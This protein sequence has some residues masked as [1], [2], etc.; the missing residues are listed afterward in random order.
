MQRNVLKTLKSL[1]KQTWQQLPFKSAKYGICRFFLIPSTPDTRV[2]MTNPKYSLCLSQRRF[3]FTRSLTYLLNVGRYASF[4]LVHYCCMTRLIGK[5]I[6]QKHH[7][8]KQLAIV[9]LHNNDLRSKVR[10]SN[11]ITQSIINQYHVKFC[12]IVEINRRC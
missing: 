9:D 4:F 3:F 2:S 1:T 11:K 8:R 12:L 7:K 10:D 6:S 5:N